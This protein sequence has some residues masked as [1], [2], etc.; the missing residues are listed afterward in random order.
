MSPSLV[1]MVARLYFSWPYCYIMF[2]LLYTS[3]Y[4]NDV[5][6]RILAKPQKSSLKIYLCASGASERFFE[7]LIVLQLKGSKKCTINVKVEVILSSKNGGED[8]CTGH[9]PPT[10]KK[11]GDTPLPPPP[12]IYASDAKTASY[13]L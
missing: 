7:F 11:W 12:R 13:R 3:L 2:A 8:I 1:S 6:K 9:P 10:Q 4:I 5:K